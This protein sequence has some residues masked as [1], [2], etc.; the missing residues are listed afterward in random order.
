VGWQCSPSHLE[1]DLRSFRDAL[2]EFGAAPLEQ[3]I[4]AAIR[5]CWAAL[6]PAGRR[7]VRFVA[8]LGLPQIPIAWLPVDLRPG[9]PGSWRLLE[10][11]GIAPRGE[12]TS[13]E[14]I[15]VHRLVASWA[16]KDMEQQS[17]SD[18]AGT[19]LGWAKADELVDELKAFDPRLRAFVHGVQVLLR[20]RF[21]KAMSEE[22]AATLR[23][24]YLDGCGHLG[25]EPSTLARF[26]RMGLEGVSVPTLPP[27]VLGQ[28]LDVVPVRLAN[29][30]Q[31]LADLRKEV[32]EILVAWFKN[33]PPGSDYVDDAQAD[34]VDAYRHLA[35]ELFRNKDQTNA[36]DVLER[37]NR[38]CAGGVERSAKRG[39]WHVLR[40]KGQLQLAGR[41]DAPDARWVL[42]L[43]EL[44]DWQ[45][46]PLPDYLRLA[47]L[48]LVVKAFSRL[49]LDELSTERREAVIREGLALCRKHRNHAVQEE[50][51]LAA[52]GGIEIAGLRGLYP[53]VV[54]AA[55]DV[56]SNSPTRGLLSRP[57]LGH[58]LFKAVADLTTPQ[59][60][61]H[62]VQAL[63]LIVPGNQKPDDYQTVRAAA[64]I[65][66]AG[67]PELAERVLR[68]IW[69]EQRRTNFKSLFW[70]ALELAKTLRWLGRSNEAAEIIGP[71]KDDSKYGA[72]VF[73]EI[74]KLEAA[75]GR[76]DDCKQN[77]LL[78]AARYETANYPA[79]AERCRRWAAGIPASIDE[80]TGILGD[81]VRN[82]KRREAAGPE[83]CESVDKDL[84]AIAAVLAHD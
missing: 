84:E 19:L 65:R 59:A 28:L 51:I 61:L 80:P 30:A 66:D 47:G 45:G 36:I 3:R 38:I 48:R 12:N 1:E 43:L 26:I 76:L 58:S 24:R 62:M 34:D 55:E 14:V 64:I 23:R 18:V 77:L 49:T 33:N 74:A 16:D 53:E 73:D 56:L 4:E 79:F 31:Y 15:R 68:P 22:D 71:F 7:R 70:T 20:H 27:V 29:S 2:E 60:L 78:N 9:P 83:Q 50:F 13:V 10:R 46:S 39:Y 21:L 11:S 17:V 42:Q 82:R 67:R 37:T 5:K 25:L 44:L 41:A 52:V 6:D 63:R 69:E 8:A 40:T 57:G 35:K 72:G 32:A 75:S 54:R 81:I